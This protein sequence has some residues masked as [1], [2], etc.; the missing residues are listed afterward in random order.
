MGKGST[1]LMRT[2][3]WASTVRLCAI[4]PVKDLHFGTQIE[5]Q[6]IALS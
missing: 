3:A 5:I 6:A 1:K 4:V 2:G